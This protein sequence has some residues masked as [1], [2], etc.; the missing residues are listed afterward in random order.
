MAKT[1]IT[2]TTCIPTAECAAEF[3]VL[4]E[5]LRNFK[6]QLVKVEKAFTREMDKLCTYLKS[7]YNA[8]QNNKIKTLETDL[9]ATK[10]VVARLNRNMI[11]AAGGAAVI[12]FLITNAVPLI[13]KSIGG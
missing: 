9:L 7:E 5:Q 6:D 4:G 1:R 3:A 10:K 11:M 13:I 2:E 12:T 8:V